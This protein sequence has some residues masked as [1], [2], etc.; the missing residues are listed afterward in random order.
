MGN[1]SLKNTLGKAWLHLSLI[2][3]N[4]FTAEFRAFGLRVSIALLI[5]LIVILIEGIVFWYLAKDSHPDVSA[6]FDGIYFIVVSIFGETTAPSSTGARV[7]TLIALAEGLILA[8]YLIA[9]SAYFT[10]RGGKVMERDHKDHVIVCGWNFQAPRIIQELL[11]AR[12]RRHFDIAV[13]PGKEAP[14]ELDQFG[15]KVFVVTGSPADDRTLMQANILEAKSVIVLSDTGL[16]A[17][18]A[19]AWAL[20]ITL[21]VETMNPKVYTCVQL[22]NSENAI[23]LTRANVDEIVPIDVL[24]ATLSVASALNPGVTKV[25]NELVHFNSGSEIYRL[26][27]PLPPDVVGT[28]F[29]E[30]AQWFTSRDMILVAI[31]SEDL[32]DSYIRGLRDPD[33]PRSPVGRGV[34][35]NPINHRI[36][37]EDALF[38]ISE[39]NPADSLT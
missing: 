16:E 25:I 28:T 30:A 1:S 29:K 31:E 35:V 14:E 11:D 5:I 27:P 4:R 13:L 15:S 23:H 24:G 7:V 2:S 6:P 20:M 26:S 37:I 18:N 32:S 10:I 33:G 34:Y 12:A 22:M 17:N 8:T 19:D 9:I 38:V 3:R 39:E 36:T 21:A